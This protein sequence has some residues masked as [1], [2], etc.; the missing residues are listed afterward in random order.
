MT[1]ISISSTINESKWL[2]W[3]KHDAEDEKLNPA[4]IVNTAAKC[5]REWLAGMFELDVLFFI[6]K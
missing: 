6:L 1:H 4:F 5:L 2:K 3:S